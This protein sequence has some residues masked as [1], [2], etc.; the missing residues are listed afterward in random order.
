MEN[1][2]RSSE[3]AL[4][5][6]QYGKEK[7]Y[8]LDKLS[9]EIVKSS[10]PYSF[11][12][13]SKNGYKI[14]ALTFKLPAELAAKLMEIS[15]N[16]DNRLHIVLVTG[17][18]ILLKKYTGNNDIVVGTSIYKQDVEGDFIN[19]VLALRNRLN[20]DTTFKELLLK[21]V[22]PTI[23]GANENQNYPI[24]TL[25]Y[26]L[27]MT[28]NRDGF[29]LFDVAVL[30][31]NIH[32]KAYLRDTK[33]NV[34][35]SF[36]RNDKSI[37][38]RLE[39]NASLYDKKTIERLTGHFMMLMGN[40]VSNLDI[41]ISDID[42]LPD[43]EK[44][45]QIVDFNNTSVDYPKTKTVDQLFTEMAKQ[46]PGKIAVH[47]EGDSLTYFQL[48]EKTTKLAAYLRSR[49]VGPEEPVGIM[50]EHSTEM[51]AGVLGI[52]KAGAAY[53]PINPDY[54]EERKKY[55]LK[56]GNAKILLTNIEVS[57]DLPVEVIRLTD[58]GIYKYDSV[59]ENDNHAGNL[60]YIMYTSGSTGQPKG[61]MVE[62]RNVIRLVK[63]TNY[64]Q[65]QEDDRILQ[66]GAL[67]FDA[68]T[69][70]IWGAL[71]NGLELH[72]VKKD[73]VLVADKLKDIIRTDKITTMW[74]TSPLFN[75]I[76][77][78]DIEIFSGIRNLIVGGDVLSPV[79]I[80]RVKN[81][82]PGLNV[83]NGY[84]PTENTTF[85][86]T[87]L[88]DTDYE[89]NIPI[90][91]PI[92][93]STAYIVDKDNRLLP[94][95]APGE[96]YVGGDGIARGYLNNPD[97]TVEKFIGM[98]EVLNAGK[99]PPLP[100]ALNAQQ[101]SL[102]RTGDLAR[103]LPDRTI[104]FLGRYDQQVKIRGYRIEPG[105][106]ETRLLKLEGISDAVV[107]VLE[108]GDGEKHLCAYV[109]SDEEID[110]PELR[111]ALAETLPDYMIPSYFVRLER[112]PLTLNGKVDRKRLPQPEINADENYAAP[113]NDVDEK[114]IEIWADL[115]GLEKNK[116]GIDTNFFEI[117]GHSLKATLLIT[118][119]HKSF[120]VKVPLG[121]IF[122]CPTIRELA[123]CMKELEEDIFQLLKVVE[124]R[125]YYELSPAQKRL[126]IA[127][128]MGKTSSLYSLPMNFIL[129]GELELRRLENAFAGLINRHESLRTSFRL[130][131]DKP[132]QKIHSQVEFAVQ[133]YEAGKN[134]GEA[135]VDAIMQQFLQ[136]FDLSHAPL[137]RV[138]LIKV[139]E[140]RHIL[141]VD[142]HHI[143]TDGTSMEIMIDEFDA[144]YR[145]ETLPDLRLQ[146]KDYSNW[147]NR[148]LLSDEIRKQE[149]Y[150]LK[151]F[152]GHIP[153]L[154][155]PTDGERS[156]QDNAAGDS[157]SFEI[158]RQDSEA[159]NALALAEGVTLY[160][161]ILAVYNVF[162]A[163][164]CQQ[165]DIL[166][167]TPVAGRRHADLELVFGMFI[168]TLCLRNFPKGDSTF[169]QFLADV[170]QR[171]LEGFE[172]QDYQFE[173]LVEKL[174]IERVPG[175]NP[176]FNV[177]FSFHNE[178]RSDRSSNIE[179]TSLTLVPYESDTATSYFDLT[180]RGIEID[181]KL[182]F[183]F[184]Y[185]NRLFEK[186]SLGIYATYF[187]KVVSCVL[188]NP[189]RKI[190]DMNIITQLH[191]E[192]IMA[193]VY[194]D[195]E[196]E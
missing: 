120:D 52:L 126:F 7:K 33:P 186:E 116:L 137:L 172:N 95:G 151:Q 111:N 163:K 31:E 61:I 106:I 190:H 76:S 16:M 45:Q 88:I 64:I 102:Y 15:S 107:I 41:N 40:A 192:K 94:L 32:E 187:Q 93:N 140:M 183:T 66:T 81:R 104:E 193:Q 121:E 145:G 143:V 23:T 122:R 101:S 168:N 10:F 59:V 53:M 17:V 60:A 83:I 69:F 65:F 191:K 135:A 185:D 8:W 117:G 142:I 36:L 77:D 146:Y 150:W 155:L 160:M 149:E 138:G 79:H 158:S 167:G 169:R 179:L 26:Q 114:L 177:S 68:S 139:T 170:K 49:E 70:E 14:D 90:G 113:R 38:C 29:P 125:E 123:D 178:V 84:G 154:N 195:L 4:A 162:L 51:I 130:V 184:Q 80:N 85:S 165:E 141:M 2:D 196:N 6:S 176:L 91:K 174:A 44:R 11:K 157:L 175:Q 25:L 96:L 82:F 54:P 87:H 86:I 152:S 58:P 131:E 5:A 28:D 97:L 147:Q 13:T 57:N 180:L 103:W 182:Y 73:T 112:I 75:Q 132:V 127:E 136:P 134:S 156:G 89:D 30:L 189:A 124:A 99:W 1:R 72:L 37:E 21:E 194:A 159:L 173:D 27:N 46:V 63:N 42:I 55:L 56:D 171:T 34:L 62:H 50:A 166:V 181:K 24:E 98:E 20:G 129:E 144:L 48:D 35:F 164:L 47:C 115:L 12:K 148:L 39:Y 9:G 19:T 67:E 108:G 153:R 119:I 105:E 100:A 43:E 18:V 92:A 128:Q 109:V 3:I 78:A 133:H 161:L 188:E 22:R 74:L 71:L 118:K 110:G